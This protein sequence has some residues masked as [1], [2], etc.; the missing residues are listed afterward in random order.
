MF[1]D[2]INAY[3]F[4]AI[5]K[6]HLLKLAIPSLPSNPHINFSTTINKYSNK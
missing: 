3:F 2:F 5:A 4:L 6:K 1:N